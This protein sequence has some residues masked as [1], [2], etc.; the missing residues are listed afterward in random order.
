[1]EQVFFESIM[2]MEKLLLDKLVETGNCFFGP[3]I[4]KLAPGG[5]MNGY[6][7]T[8]QLPIIEWIIWNF[9]FLNFHKVWKLFLFEF[10]FFFLIA[11]APPPS[12]KKN[13]II[14]T[15]LIIMTHFLRIRYRT[16]LAAISNN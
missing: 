9:I 6:F 2:V 11:T 5:L 8:S 13:E 4:F 12:N 3:A 14:I 7:H 15:L 16:D 1:M 10:I